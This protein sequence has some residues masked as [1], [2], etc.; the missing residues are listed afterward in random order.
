M[1][2][3]GNDQAIDVGKDRL[4]R[5]ALFRRRGRKLSFEIAG[6]DLRQDGQVFDMF[7][8]ICD[9][10]DDLVAIASEFFG[11]HIAEWVSIRFS[12]HRHAT[13]GFLQGLFKHSPSVNHGCNCHGVMLN[14]VDDA[15][16]VNKAFP[17]IF[18]IEFRHNAT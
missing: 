10:V 14:A 4:H 9:P 3:R 8:V 11:G 16:A 15:E 12:I 1:R 17:K 6:L 5:L 13:S 2:Q 7:E 18:V